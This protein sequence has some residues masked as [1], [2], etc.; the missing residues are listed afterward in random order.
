[1]KRKLHPAKLACIC[2]LSASLALMSIPLAFAADGQEDFTN[3]KATSTVKLETKADQL[4]ATIP[5]A[6]PLVAK[7]LGGEVTVPTGYKIVNGS[8][9]EIYITSIKGE[10][11]TPA[12]W[13]LSPTA[14]AENAAAPADK[15]V[16]S[17]FMTID[18][19]TV[20]EGTLVLAGD[21]AITVPPSATAGGEKTL[22]L[23]ASTSVLK[24]YIDTSKQMLTVTYTI[25]AAKTPAP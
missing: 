10:I 23:V 20:E 4:K 8:S 21:D 12:D 24:K 7:P 3:N 15:S 11:I 5:T 22:P 17:L 14:L 2:V 16:G 1:M 19:K 13:S 9:F 6:I 18:G 25:A